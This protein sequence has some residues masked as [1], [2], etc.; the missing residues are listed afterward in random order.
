MWEFE[1]LR[2]LE[3]ASKRT[4]SDD[5]DERTVYDASGKIVVTTEYKAP[6]PI[7]ART[8][9]I[10]VSGDKVG[11][12]KANRSVRGIVWGTIFVGILGSAF[13]LCVY[14]L[15][16]F[17]PMR[18]LNEALSALASEKEKHE[19]TLSSIGDGVITVD[20]EGRIA[21]DEPGGREVHRMEIR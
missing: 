12:V 3:I 18:L 13:G 5:E 21:Y 9:P 14:L 1:T 19:M 16:R 15:F 4:V 11:A 2:L 10:F 7:I 20:R 8:A 17:Y 6:A